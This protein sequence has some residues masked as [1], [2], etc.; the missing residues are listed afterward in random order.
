MD[1]QELKGANLDQEFFH[2]FQHMAFFKIFPDFPE[3]NLV[4]LD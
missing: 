2:F 4:Q 3:S 1:Y